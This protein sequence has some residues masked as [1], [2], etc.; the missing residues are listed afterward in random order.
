MCSRRCNTVGSEDRYL[1]KIGAWSK[2]AIVRASFIIC[3]A[4]CKMKRQSPLFK[5]DITNATCK[6]SNK[7][8]E[9]MH[10]VFISSVHMHVSLSPWAS[11]TKHKFKDKIIVSW[12]WL[13]G[14]KIMAGP[15]WSWSPVG[16]HRSHA[17]QASLRCCATH[18]P[19]QERTLYK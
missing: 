1:F 6:W 10:F 19:L 15:S 8:T 5:K 2:R 18:F 14:V 3:M 16:P 12:Q 4:P 13:Q 17:Q 7:K 9:N 11:L